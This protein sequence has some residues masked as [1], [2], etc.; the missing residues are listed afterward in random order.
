[1]HLVRELDDGVGPVVEQPFEPIELALGI[2]SD[3]IRDLDILALDD[4][5]HAHLRAVGS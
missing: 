5:P 1:M 2:G 4:G 3:A